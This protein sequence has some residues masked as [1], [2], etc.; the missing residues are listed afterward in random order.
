MCLGEVSEYW[1]GTHHLEI[2]GLYKTVCDCS[3]GDPEDDGLPIDG[4]TTYSWC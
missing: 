4:D 2:N 3:E 1:D